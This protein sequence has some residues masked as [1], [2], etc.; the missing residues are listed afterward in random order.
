[1][2]DGRYF[3]N[4]KLPYLTNSWIDYHE[5][6]TFDAYGPSEPYRPLKVRI[7]KIQDGWRPPSRI[8]RQ[9]F[10]RLPR[11]LAQLRITALNPI[12]S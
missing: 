9:R 11:N 7:L 5:I 6:W 10:N 8:T 2:A 12:D 1:M 4:V 3:W